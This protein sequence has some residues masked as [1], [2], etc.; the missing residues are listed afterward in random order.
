MSG[1]TSAHAGMSHGG[2]ST[3]ELTG[4]REDD[5]K[6]YVGQRVEI[7]GSVENA[8]SGADAS[9]GGSAA[10][11]GTANP[12]SGTTANPTS[13]TASGST[14]APGSAPAGVSASASGDQS[15]P[16][17]RITSFRA[18]GGDCAAAGGNR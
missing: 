7:T 18:V 4:D 13:S 17:L 2:A 5:L 1:S 11:S 16:R 6:Q 8:Q 9:M 15:K 14:S 12:A 3:Y 10:G